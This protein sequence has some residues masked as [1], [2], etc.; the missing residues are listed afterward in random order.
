V[1]EQGW[2]EVKE[3]LI[4]GGQAKSFFNSTFLTTKGSI[5]AMN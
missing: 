4:V 2:Y 5:I 1:G 3:N